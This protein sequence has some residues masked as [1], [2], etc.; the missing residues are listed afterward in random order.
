M[1]RLKSPK[2]GEERIMQNCYNRL[3][4]PIESQSMDLHYW[5]YFS[6]PWAANIEF[7]TRHQELTR[8]ESWAFVDWEIGQNELPIPIKIRPFLNLFSIFSDKCHVGY[9]QM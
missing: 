6:S 4:I 1:K 3:K 7:E 5:Q 2:D 9:Y 8:Y